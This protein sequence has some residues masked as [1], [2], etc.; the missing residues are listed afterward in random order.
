MENT[1]EIVGQQIDQLKAQRD[2]KILLEKTGLKNE[3]QAQLNEAIDVSQT[4][5][6][7]LASSKLSWNETYSIQLKEL[8]DQLNQLSYFKIN[9]QVQKYLQ[10]VR[11]KNELIVVVCKNKEEIDSKKL[12]FVSDEQLK[13]NQLRHS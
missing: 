6:N 11:E 1:N 10:Q 8:E 2:L 12:D 4:I 3:L 5:V 9:K 7:L 13:K